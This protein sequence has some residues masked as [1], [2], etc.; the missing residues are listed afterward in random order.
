MAEDRNVRQEEVRCFV[1]SG[2]SLSCYYNPPDEIALIE[3]LV[4]T[5]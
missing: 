1:Q 2:R 5:V 4:W 3:F